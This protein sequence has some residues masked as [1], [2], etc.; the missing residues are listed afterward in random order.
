MARIDRVRL[1]DSRSARHGA[2]PVRTRGSD[3]ST[4]DCFLTI[5]V[6]ASASDFPS[7]SPAIPRRLKAES[8]LGLAKLTI[9]STSSRSSPSL[10]RGA[11]RLGPVGVEK[12]GKLPS[13][14]MPSSSLPQLT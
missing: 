10:A 12:S 9:P 5:L 13:E 1:V 8:P 7:S 11:P 3:S 14:I 6:A 4:V 2:F